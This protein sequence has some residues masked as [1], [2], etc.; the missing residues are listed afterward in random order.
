MSSNIPFLDIGQDLSNLRDEIWNGGVICANLN[1]ELEEMEMFGKEK[2]TMKY[3]DINLQELTIFSQKMDDYINELK[4][5]KT[6]IEGVVEET[7]NYVE[8]YQNHIY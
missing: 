3:I 6:K 8:K 2:N 7:R 4:E 1:A 5:L